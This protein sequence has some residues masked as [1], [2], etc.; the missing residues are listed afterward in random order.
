MTC[1]LTSSY[2]REIPD[3]WRDFQNA[4]RGFYRFNVRGSIL[5]ELMNGE[6]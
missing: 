3:I 5:S 6:L 2:I 1:A 4:L